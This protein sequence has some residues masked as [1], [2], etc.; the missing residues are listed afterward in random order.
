MNKKMNYCTKTTGFCRAYKVTVLVDIQNI[1]MSM[2]KLV[3]SMHGTEAQK[4]VKEYYEKKGIPV[5]EISSEVIPNNEL[6]R[7]RITKILT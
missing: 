3:V 5:I 1:K 4:A 6:N 7:S 2:S